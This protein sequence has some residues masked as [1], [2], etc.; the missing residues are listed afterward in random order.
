MT[1]PG[2]SNVNQANTG[3]VKPR[4][5]MEMVVGVLIQLLRELHPG[6]LFL[7]EKKE[8]LFSTVYGSFNNSNTPVKIDQA[9][10]REAEELKFKKDNPHSSVQTQNNVNL[11]NPPASFYLD[12]VNQAYMAQMR[13]NKISY[14]QPQV[15]EDNAQSL[16][17]PPSENFNGQPAQAQM[18]VKNQ[19]K[20]SKTREYD[21]QTLIF[22][23]RVIFER[24]ASNVDED[25]PRSS[26][27]SSITVYDQDNRQIGRKVSKKNQ[28]KSNKTGA[29]REKIIL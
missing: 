3:A 16:F 18:I 12:P 27:S 7:P 15:I 14:A 19:N 29:V 11:A 4:A 9:Y 23:N 22:N 5:T 2:P 20:K 8:E 6:N 1:N 13:E 24:L 25:F 10:L 26:V 28:N 21:E 17:N